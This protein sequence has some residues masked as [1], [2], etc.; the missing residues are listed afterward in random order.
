MYVIVAPGFQVNINDVMDCRE[1][2]PWAISRTFS[3]KIYHEA[4]KVLEE[5]KCG[6][7]V[8]AK[9]FRVNIND[10]ALLFISTQ[11]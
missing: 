10:N 2:I 4:K 8:I 9:A 7:I 1:K 3:Y 11:K 5:I 6:N